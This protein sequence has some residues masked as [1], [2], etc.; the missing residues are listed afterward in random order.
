MCESW[1]QAFCKILIE[2][3]RQYLS[4]LSLSM[5]FRLLSLVVNVLFVLG[6]SDLGVLR[7]LGCLQVE[8]AQIR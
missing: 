3:S 6:R 8:A 7:Y 1:F 2:P 5:I 4:S